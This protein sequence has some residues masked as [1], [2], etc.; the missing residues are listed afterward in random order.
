MTRNEII[1]ANPLERF[2]TKRGTNFGNRA[3][4][5]SPTLVRLLSTR[6]GIAQ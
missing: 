2:L 5:V 6:S 4:I 1:A 3:R